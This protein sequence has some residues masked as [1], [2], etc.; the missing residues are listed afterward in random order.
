MST[1]SGRFV[2]I[3]L[4]IRGWGGESLGQ[5]KED[6]AGA[7]DRGDVLYGRGWA[8]WVGGHYWEGWVLASAG[9][10]A[11]DSSGVESA[12]QFDGGRAGFGASGG[13][14]L[15]LLGAAGFGSVLGVPG[16]VAE[17]GG[18]RVRYGDLSGDLCALSG[19]D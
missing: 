5:V 16:G 13:G 15:L 19:E 10:V 18:Q 1:G 11:G 8:V 12:D 2:F 6:A 9:A 3:K 17:Y 7:A 14:R 4:E